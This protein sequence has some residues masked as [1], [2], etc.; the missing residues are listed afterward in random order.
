MNKD[1]SASLPRASNRGSIGDGIDCYVLGP[2]PEDAILT[3]RGLMRVLTGSTGGSLYRLLAGLPEHRWSELGVDMDRLRQV[4]RRGAAEPDEKDTERPLRTA[5]QAE[6]DPAAELRFLTPDGTV[7]HGISGLAAVRI[8]D[9]Y[10]TS[11]MANELRKSQIPIAQRAHK[12][13]QGFNGIGVVTVI[14]QATGYEVPALGH[15]VAAVATH[16]ADISARLARLEQRRPGSL[17]ISSND[18]MAATMLDRVISMA[19]RSERIPTHTLVSRL[20]LMVPKADAYSLIEQAVAEG[21]LHY[22]TRDGSQ[23]E[24]AADQY[25]S[26]LPPKRGLWANAG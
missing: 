21:R 26:C 18:S 2:R 17:A 25:V 5:Q 16:L 11:S 20:R 3:N 6:E 22:V 23:W 9:V 7:A 1:L 19:Q 12:A 13:L 8:L 14:R 10:V 15:E 24:I 4:S